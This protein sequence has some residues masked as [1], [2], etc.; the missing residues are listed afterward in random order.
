MIL[1][2]GIL[3]L[4]VVVVVLR[5]HAVPLY[6]HVVAPEVNSCPFIGLFGKS[7]GINHLLKV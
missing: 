1:P 6:A 7:I 4:E 2:T 3:S 5:S